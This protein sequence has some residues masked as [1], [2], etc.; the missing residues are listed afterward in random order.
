MLVLMLFVLVCKTMAVDA[1]ASSWTLPSPPNG[2]SNSDRLLSDIT[3][4][5]RCIRLA[6]KE[7]NEWPNP[8][9]TDQAIQ[10][11][12][13]LDV[14]ASVMTS[15]G[16][17]S[18]MIAITSLHIPYCLIV[19]NRDNIP[20]SRSFLQMYRR[21]TESRRIRQFIH[22]YH[23]LDQ[24]NNIGQF[25][26]HIMSLVIKRRARSR[27]IYLNAERIQQISKETEVVVSSS[28]ATLRCSLARM[29]NATVTLEV[30]SL[31]PYASRTY[32]ARWTWDLI[33]DGVTM[34]HIIC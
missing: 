16:V 19:L 13:F 12:A 24:D 29:I 3:S 22:K 34:Q 23:L 15:S 10:R 32:N 33:P 5:R 4:L 17:L 18:A 26:H 20:H 21:A 2:M 6:S 1:S 9:T 25:S 30:L 11:I 7:Q 27:I 14:N 8:V 31:E 28:S